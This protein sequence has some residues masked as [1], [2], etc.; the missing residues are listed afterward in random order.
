MFGLTV[1]LALD[2]GHVVFAVEHRLVGV[3]GELPVV[4]GDP[5]V[6][7]PAHQLVLVPAVPDQVGDGDEVQ[8]VLVGELDQLGQPGHARLVLADHLAQDAGRGHARRP[9][10]IDG[11]LGVARP[12]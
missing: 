2:Q 5:G 6:G 11:R 8:P 1:D 9:G 4:G 12:A 3:D 7:D 10:Q